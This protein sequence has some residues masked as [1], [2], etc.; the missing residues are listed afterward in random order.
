M[1]RGRPWPKKHAQASISGF[2]LT[3]QLLSS[4]TLAFLHRQAYSMFLKRLFAGLRG[5]CSSRNCCAFVYSV[6]SSG[7]KSILSDVP[8]FVQPLVMVTCIAHYLAVTA[9]CYAYAA[10]PFP[11]LCEILRKAA[12]HCVSSVFSF[13]QCNRRRKKRS[14]ISTHTPTI[15]GHYIR[16]F[17]YMIFL[18]L[19][20]R[21]F[22]FGCFLFFFFLLVEPAGRRG[23]PRLAVV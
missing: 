21:S 23:G 17:C 1:G 3:F 15:P 8:Q 16:T 11:S 10:S 2:F 19:F 7:T 14:S 6:L 12:G 13:F 5:T 18:F 9:A 22:L 20:L 4:G